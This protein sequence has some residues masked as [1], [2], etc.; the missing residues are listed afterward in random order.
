[1]GVEQELIDIESAKNGFTRRQRKWVRNAY[2][3]MFGSLFCV[4]P[5]WNGEEY[6]YCGRE[7]VEVHHIKPRGWCIRVLK[8]DPNIPENAAPVC[9]EHHRLGQRHKPLTRKDQEVI[10]LDAAYANR[11]YDKGIKPS[12]YDK[13]KD[14]RFR[15]CGEVTPYWY[16]LWDSYLLELAEDIIGEFKRRYPHLCWPERYIKDC[17]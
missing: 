8:I 4:F 6:V 17:D 2:E 10:H 9:P 1:M 7:H 14:Q 16:E 3:S 5:V 11:N 15:L 13:I 12:S